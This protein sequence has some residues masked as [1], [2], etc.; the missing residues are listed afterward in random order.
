MG[1][2]KMDFRW[3]SLFTFIGSG[4]WCCVLVWVGVRAGD[5]AQLLKGDMRRITLWIC[6]AIAIIGSLYYF[7]VHR[8]MSKPAKEL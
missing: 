6:G 3:Y 8:Y 5:D 7:F 1:I 2:V 4:I